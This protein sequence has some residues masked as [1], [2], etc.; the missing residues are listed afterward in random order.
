[1]WSEHTAVQVVAWRMLSRLRAAGWPQELDQMYLD[2]DT[3]AW[4]QATGEGEEDETKVIHR[5]SN[6]VILELETQ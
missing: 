2:E 4:A 1:M 5:D 6:G 3:L